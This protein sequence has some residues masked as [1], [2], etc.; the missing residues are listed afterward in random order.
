MHLLV[1]VVGRQWD[2]FIFNPFFENILIIIPKNTI[3]NSDPFGRAI[4]RGVTASL[5]RATCSGAAS[6]TTVATGVD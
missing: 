4:V 2:F 1:K 5:C 6:R 3:C